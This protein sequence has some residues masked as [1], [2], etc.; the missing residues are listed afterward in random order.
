MWSQHKLAWRSHPLFRSFQDPTP[1]PWESTL[2][3]HTARTH[4]QTNTQTDRQTDTHTQ[5]HIDTH[6]Q[7]HTDTHTDPHTHTHT[8]T[9]THRQ[10]H[11]QTHT[12][13]HTHT[14][15]HTHT[16]PHTQ[17]HTQRHTHRDTHTHTHTVLGGGPLGPP[18]A[19]PTIGAQSLDLLRIPCRADA[20]RRVQSVPSN[21]LW[22]GARQS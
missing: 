7:T 5:T 8:H 22:A 14:Q 9:E 3:L 17:T 16:D 12:H 19:L 2:S 20:T 6:T 18:H 10:T 11:R 21:E 4:T 1:T 15:T 13:R